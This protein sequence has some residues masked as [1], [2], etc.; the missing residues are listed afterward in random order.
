MEAQRNALLV[1]TAKVT[2]TA[3]VA[4]ATSAM[5]AAT[6]LGFVFGFPDLS[7][8]FTLAPVVGLVAFPFV[9]VAKCTMIANHWDGIVAH[10]FAG[11]LVGLLAS[12]LIAQARHITDVIVFAA[13]GMLASL[14]Y[15]WARNLWRRILQ[16]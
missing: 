3:L 14:S 11:A 10:A 16:W 5:V 9:F 12:I 6:A 4:Y 13:I 15:L 1:S 2:T 8:A 7:F